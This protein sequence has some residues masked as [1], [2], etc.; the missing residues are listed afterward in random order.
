M[1]R[2]CFMHSLNHPKNWAF[3][4]LGLAMC[5]MAGLVDDHVA[6]DPDAILDDLARHAAHPVLPPLARRLGLAGSTLFKPG[7]PTQ[8]NHLSLEDFVE[9]EYKAFAAASRAELEAVP[10]VSNLLAILG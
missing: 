1:A 4:D 9:E 5:R 6:I 2:G 3:A 8:M 10:M 7:H